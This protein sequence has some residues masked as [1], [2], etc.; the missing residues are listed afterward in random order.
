MFIKILQAECMKLKRKWLWFLLFLG[1]A[2]VVGLTLVDYSVRYEYLIQQ[3]PN[4]W[5]GLFH[6][7][8]ITL[9]TAF[10]LGG[11]ILASNIAHVEY[12]RS[13][14][15]H[16]LSLPV[17]RLSVYT[18]KFIVVMAMLLIASAF[19]SIGIIGLGWWLGFG[20]PSSWKTLFVYNFYPFFSAIP[21][22]AI[23]I[24]L[25]MLFKNQSRSLALGIMM[26]VTM[27]GMGELP[28]WFIWQ[29][30]MLVFSDYR[31]TYMITGAIIGI[32]LYGAGAFHFI[33]KDV[34]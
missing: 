32:F 33:R 8:N 30:P 28:S 29:W 27:S 20:L 14:W 19:L 13:S 18:A 31:N 7:I 25:S 15:K 11:T 5:E 22:V 34:A 23:Q 1:P 24:W 3:N 16:L 12:H 6:E 9:P 4:V 17:T 2:G 21:F 26:S 10:L